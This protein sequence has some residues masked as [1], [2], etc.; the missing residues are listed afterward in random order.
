M[1]TS[2]YQ[3]NRDLLLV[4]AL[5]AILTV[6][7]API[8]PVVIDFAIIANFGMALTILLMTFYVRRPVDFSTFPSILLIVT[9]LRLAINVA[10]TRLILTKADAGEVISAVGAFAV[11]GNYIVGFVV[12]IIL[13]VVQFVVVTSGSQRVSEVAARFTLDSM[14]G[15]QMSIDADLNMGLIDQVE[16]QR[17]RHALE[18]EAAFYGAMD[19]A[20]K[21][22]KGDAIAAIIILLIN[23]IAGSLIGIL[24][25]GLSWRDALAH[26]SLLTIG[27]GIAAQLPALIVSVAT[28]IIVTR[29]SADRDLSTE[30]YAQLSSI[31]RIPII[32][33]IALMLL[34]LLPGMP[35]WPIAIVVS[36]LG[37]ALWRARKTARQVPD[38]DPDLV[39]R[40]ALPTAE[41]H[42]GIEIL[43]GAELSAG[44]ADR[45]ELLLERVGALRRAHMTEFGT[46][47]PP[48]RL[49]EEEGVG[50]H[51]FEVRMFGTRFSLMQVFADR[52]LAVAPHGKLDRIEGLEV[53]SLFQG[54]PAFWI[55]PEMAPAAR[56]KGYHVVEP[57]GA[58]FACLADTTRATAPRLL[59]RPVM[60]ELIDD[61]RQHNPGVVEDLIPAMLSVAEVQRVLR[62]LLT[63]GVS[64]A[65]LELIFEEL[66]DLARNQRDPDDLAELLRHRIGFAICD[67]LRGNHRDL[68]VI[69]LD[70][71]LE[72]ELTG[73]LTSPGRIVDP[74]L[75]E[76]LI[77]NL[78]PITD[79]MIECGRAPVLLCGNE[80][81]RAI[82]LLTARAIP[83]LSV[84]SVAEIPERIDL[85][86][87]DVVKV[88]TQ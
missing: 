76:N 64:I 28:G 44:L 25:L 5:L 72:N 4:G 34:M 16:A 73:T 8:P 48:V 52:L 77:R 88:D 60:V 70:P 1:F 63:E 30:I 49:R 39:T 79:R 36:L 9:L 53:E 61:L 43:L 78:L 54:Q 35:K 50:L 40:S 84:I 2:V 68:A 67:K 71:R 51:D 41:R 33:G 56:E 19:G 55:A 32:V 12:F 17:R 57:V 11:G 3:N 47:L 87:F 65:N 20:S 6:L 26:F 18:Q 42:N 69:S 75:A 21:F 82:R 86:S 23:I 62:N 66:V 37:M 45:R 80:V 81:R 13:V 46:P 29:S 74:R 27:D 31:P 22:V 24:Q 85:S 83:R 14:P 10:A 58:M 15:Q 59:T 38:D 7:F